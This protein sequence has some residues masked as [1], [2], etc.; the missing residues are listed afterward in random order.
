VV[1]LRHDREEAAV[2]DR[3]WIQFCRTLATV[4]DECS[5]DLAEAIAEEQRD[6]MAAGLVPVDA[7][8]L[9]PNLYDAGIYLH[10]CRLM[11][12]ER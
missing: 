7:D 12:D 4:A 2:D 1:G 3:E 6:L 9:M 11:E 10:A 8:T 5:D